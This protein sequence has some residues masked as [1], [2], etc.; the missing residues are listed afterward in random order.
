MT[1]TLLDPNDTGEIKRPSDL[2]DD[3]T[4]NLAKFVMSAPT[5]VLAYADLV[6]AARRPD[7]TVELP[8]LPIVPGPDSFLPPGQPQVPRPLPSPLPTRRRPG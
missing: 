8:L 5:E 3:P 1:D 4:R 6:N 2:G 7:V